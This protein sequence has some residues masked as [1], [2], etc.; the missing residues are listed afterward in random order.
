M[1]QATVTF[2]VL[3]ALAVLPTPLAAQSAAACDRTCLAG[4]MTAYLNSL[5]AHDR[6]PLRR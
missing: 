1:R 6:S 4:V 2:L 5:V 3:L